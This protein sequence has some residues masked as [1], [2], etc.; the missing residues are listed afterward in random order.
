MMDGAELRTGSLTRFAV[1][2]M[3]R[4][5]TSWLMERFSAHP[6]VGGYGELLLAGRGGF[7]LIGLSART[8]VRFLPAI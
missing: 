6:R 8:I 7:A 4:S 1:L 2:S 3:P 5:G